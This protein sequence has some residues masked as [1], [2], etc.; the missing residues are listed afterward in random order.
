MS[1]DPLLQYRNRRISKRGAFDNAVVTAVYVDSDGPISASDITV[2]GD[3]TATSYTLSSDMTGTSVSLTDAMY[4]LSSATDAT[5]EKGHTISN[6]DNTA[7][8]ITQTSQLITELKET[9]TSTADDVVFASGTLQLNTS[10]GSNPAMSFV[11]GQLLVDTVGVY[12]NYTSMLGTATENRLLTYDW[13]YKPSVG[14]HTYTI[15]IRADQNSNDVTIQPDS[16]MAFRHV[17]M[18]NFS[19]TKETWTLT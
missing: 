8:T 2:T 9:F 15:N 10:T 14:E 18:P 19:L 1:T 7:T 4:P 12:S 3:T 17:N 16:Y 11:G 6:S 5:R 13:A